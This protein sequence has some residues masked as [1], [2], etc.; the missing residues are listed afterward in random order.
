MTAQHSSEAVQ[1]KC[2]SFSVQPIPHP[3]PP[4]FAGQR[5]NRPGRSRPGPRGKHALCLRLRADMRGQYGSYLLVEADTGPR[6][7]GGGNY[8]QLLGQA[9]RECGHGRTLRR[10]A[11][12]RSAA[13]S[14]R[15]APARMSSILRREGDPLNLPQH[16]SGQCGGACARRVSVRILTRRTRG[17]PWRATETGFKC[18]SHEVRFLFCSVVLRGP[19]SSSVLKKPTNEPAQTEP[20]KADVVAAGTVKCAPSWGLRRS[21]GNDK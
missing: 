6:G 14:N 3:R 21:A 13:I 19:P 4:P 17:E 5:Q 9:K 16:R 11:A 10:T 8:L 18:A 2:S 15:A 12:G 20:A 1:P 7:L